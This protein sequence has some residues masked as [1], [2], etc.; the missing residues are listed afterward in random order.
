[1]HK[2]ELRT[3]IY[4]RIEEL[5]TL[6]SALPR[7]MRLMED[8]TVSAAR[9]ADIIA[10]DPSLTSKILKAANSA[11]YGF[12]QQIDTLDRAIALLGFNMVRSL[13]MSIGI[14]HSLPSV[15]PCSHFSEEG[16]WT[17]SLAVAGAM[18][19]LAR[20]AGP[21]KSRDHI[22]LVGLLHDIGKVVL[23]E[24]FR[25][26][27]LQAL[28]EAQRPETALLHVAERRIF[29]F[30]HGEVGAMLLTRWKIPP[31]I[32]GPIGVHHGRGF[33]EGIE[34]TDVALLRVSDALCQ[35]LDLGEGGS[36]AP[37][38][39]P[40]EERKILRI[41]D[42]ELQSVKDHLEASREAIEGFFTKLGAH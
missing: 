2:E 34:D 39:L 35:G 42:K 28:E 29:G 1:M 10:G 15:P 19:C 20:G 37:V 27:F 9:V 8:D 14:M 33:P 16:L 25:E 23:I 41:G 26:S 38:P 12:P 17:H 40:V 24:F 36:P 22:F 31:V 7:L 21:G 11:Y 32:I 4:S 3:T 13:A 30:D 5:P 18:E 6:P